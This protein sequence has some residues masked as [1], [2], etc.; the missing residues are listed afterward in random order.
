MNIEQAHE[1][2]IT[3]PQRFNRGAVEN[4]LF[5]VFIDKDADV[6]IMHITDKRSDILNRDLRAK[7]CAFYKEFVGVFNCFVTL[8]EFQED[9]QHVMVQHQNRK[10]GNGKLH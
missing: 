6:R 3:G 8:E 9:I 1:R 5:A 7:G 2:I 4:I 10:K